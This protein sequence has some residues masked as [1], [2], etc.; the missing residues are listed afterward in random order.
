ME[1]QGG[2]AASGLRDT[3]F[4]QGPGPPTASMAGGVGLPLSASHSEGRLAA[5]AEF[6]PRLLALPHLLKLGLCPLALPAFRAAT[7][8]AQ[9]GAK[10]GQV[11][12]WLL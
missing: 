1:T 5:K 8:W 11:G 10:G 7:V 12:A 6:S 2:L 3:G 9:L 4:R